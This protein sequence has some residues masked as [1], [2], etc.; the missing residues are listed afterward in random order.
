MKSDFS[1]ILLQWYS[2]QKRDLPW[3]K[4]PKPYNVWLS[5]VILQQ[6]RVVQGLSYYHAFSETFPTVHDLANAPEEKVMKLWQ[7]LG[8]YSRARNMHHTAKVVSKD[9][10]GHFP[11]TASELQKLKGIGPYTA[12]AISSICFGEQVPVVDGNVNRVISRFFG[13]EIPV[14]SNEGKKKIYD[15]VCELVP[16]QKPG[17]FNQAMMEFGA[18][19]CTPQNP[20]CDKCPLSG[21]CYALRKKKVTALPL[22]T[23]KKEVRKLFIYYLKVEFKSIQFIRKRTEPG[24]WR[25][26]YEFPS[27]ESFSEKSEEDILEHLK[28]TGIPVKRISWDSRE[29]R[30]ILSHRDITAKLIQIELKNDR[31]LPEEWIKISPDE[32]S[33]FAVSR[34][35]EKITEE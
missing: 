6:T 7:G 35:M 12:A 18:L 22:K 31:G 4:N 15:I 26:L 8:Y 25:N 5:E 16:E 28:S 20:A 17:D 33:G 32:L 11:V 27:I 30:H 9:M 13:V 19:A 3:R 23:P 10:N 21:A 14:D 29:Y 34:L 1:D 2:G 24:I